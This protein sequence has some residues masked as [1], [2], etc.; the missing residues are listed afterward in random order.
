MSNAKVDEHKIRGGISS[1]NIAQSSDAAFKDVDEEL[2]NDVHIYLK[3]G[4]SWDESKG[5]IEI[6]TADID[7]AELYAKEGEGLTGLAIAAII[8]GA[9]LVALLIIGLIAA[10]VNSSDEDNSSSDSNSNSNSNSGDS[11]SGASSDGSN[12]SSDGS[13]CYVATMVYGSYEAP[14]V[15]ILRAFRDQFLQR[16]K[17]GRAFIHWYYAKSPALVEQ[18]QGKPLLRKAI[19]SA[20]D[21]FVFLITPIYRK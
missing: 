12:S 9:F 13:G 16:F 4:N 6:E 1:E 2:K 14:K 3:D 10:A 15:L 21:V 5:E 19:K 17:W 7:S 8:V 20:L 11:G 18:H